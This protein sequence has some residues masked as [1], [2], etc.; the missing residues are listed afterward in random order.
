MPIR[1]EFVPASSVSRGDSTTA[2]MRNPIA[3]YR[4]MTPSP[5]TIS[6][7]IVMTAMSSRRKEMLSNKS[8][9]TVPS[10]TTPLAFDFAS[11]PNHR[12]VICGIAT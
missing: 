9:C 6:R 3:V 1:S 11:V 12:N 8:Y 5:T 7:P 4:N 2:R 10:G